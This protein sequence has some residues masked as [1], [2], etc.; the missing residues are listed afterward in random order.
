MDVVFR[1]LGLQQ[2]H[3][4]DLD[5]VAHTFHNLSGLLITLLK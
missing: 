1:F 5:Q 4:L 3:H 2:V